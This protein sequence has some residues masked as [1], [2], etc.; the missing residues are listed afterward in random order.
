[1]RRRVERDEF[2][3]LRAAG[4]V[5]AAIG[6][7]PREFVGIV[8]A[9]IAVFT[10]FANALFLQKGPHPAP[11]FATR[12]YMASEAPVAPRVTATQPTNAPDAAAQIR[13]QLISDIQRELNRRGFYDGA[14]DGVWGAKTDAAAREFVQAAGLK[15]NVEANDSLLRAIVA[16]RVKASRAVTMEP[17]RKDPIAELIA[18]SKRV[19]AFQ[20][21][22]AEFGYGPIKFTGTY[23][24]DTRTAIE[25][26]ERDRR[27]PVTGEISDRV[28]R[29][30]AAM[31]G[32]PLE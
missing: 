1:M 8:M 32:R 4:K 13:T 14:L 18:P 10:I 19:L 15:M 7:H 11:I 5:A 16:S 25:K 6:R 28:V 21:A 12:P 26:F 31:T 2:V 27:L 3:A 20:R 9:T 29:E 23:D 22:L 17:V 24:L 30:L